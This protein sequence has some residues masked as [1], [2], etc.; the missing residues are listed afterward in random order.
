MAGVTKYPTSN[1]LATFLDSPDPVY[2]SGQDGNAT[3]NTTNGSNNTYSSSLGL[4][5]SSSVFTMTRDLFLNNLTIDNNIQLKTAGYRLF[6]KN[7]LS[8]GNGS[9]V[10]FTSGWSTAGSIAQGGAGSGT[11]VAPSLGGSAS[12]TYT[13]TPPTAAQGGTLYWQQPFQAIRGYLITASATTPTYLRG[14]AGSGGNDGG[15]F[16]IVAA[17]YISCSAT[18]TNAKIAAPGISPAGGGVVFVISSAA[19]LPANVSTDVTGANAGTYN[20][21]QV[22]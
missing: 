22:V 1:A 3:L 7:L 14:G 12:S 16:V 15:G 17:R 21:M 19:A 18:T 9:I 13:A 10:G 6:V 11:S 8:L 5:Y 4:S 2:G 20:Y